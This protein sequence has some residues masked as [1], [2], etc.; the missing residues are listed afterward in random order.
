[1]V[2]WPLEGTVT[3]TALHH[4][5][6]L[7]NIDVCR[8]GLSGG[9]KRSGQVPYPKTVEGK[10]DRTVWARTGH[11]TKPI[12]AGRWPPNILFVHDAVCGL[13]CSPMCPVGLLDGMSEHPS[14]G[15]YPTFPTFGHA[16]EWLSR[17]VGVSD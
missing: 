3:E 11:S 12:D 8:V 2:R 1:V 17:L 15:Y 4:G 6:G 10:E 14:V 7:L 5:C 13:R 9:T 16:V